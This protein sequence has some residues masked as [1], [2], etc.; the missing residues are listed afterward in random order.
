MLRILSDE[1]VQRIHTGSLEILNDVGIV[2]HH[3]SALRSLREAGTIVDHQKQAAKIPPEIVADG[4]KRSRGP[5]TLAGRLQEEYLLKLTP[6]ELPSI[7]SS[8]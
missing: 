2:I 5:G 7:Q 4:I 1:D 8:A 3:E 6:A